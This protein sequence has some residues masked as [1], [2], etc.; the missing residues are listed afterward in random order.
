MFAP[1]EPIH[2]VLSFPPLPGKPKSDHRISCSNE[3]VIYASCST[4]SHPTLSSPSLLSSPS[5]AQLLFTHCSCYPWWGNSVHGLCLFSKILLSSST[6]SV[7]FFFCLTT[8]PPRFPSLVLI[9]V[10]HTTQVTHLLYRR[11]AQPL[12]ATRGFFSFFSN[13]LFFPPLSPVLTIHP[14]TGLLLEKF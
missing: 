9:P 10:F 14:S 2:S 8:E 4:G 3:K 1:S 7:F 5:T 6:S 13:T 12:A 11:T